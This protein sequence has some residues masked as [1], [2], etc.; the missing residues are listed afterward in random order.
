M[1]KRPTKVVFGNM[2]INYVGMMERGDL[3]DSKSIAVRRVGSNPTTDTIIYI[4]AGMAE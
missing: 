4:Y 3:I 1:V 2:M